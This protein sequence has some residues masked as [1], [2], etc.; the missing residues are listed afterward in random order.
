MALTKS[1]SMPP[2]EAFR[3]LSQD[4]CFGL[5]RDVLAAANGGDHIGEHAVP[6]GIVGSKKN[7]VVSDA[8]DHVGEGLLFWFRR[9]EPVA[10]F[11]VLARFFLAKRCFHLSPFLPFFIHPLDPVGNPANAA[12]KKGHAQVSKSF[13]NAAIHQAGELDKSLH[14][15]TDRMHEY[16]TV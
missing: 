2:V 3:V 15:P 14:R 16:E 12:F 5:F 13:R 9:K 1:V 6:M 10:M 8:L 11:D 7:L 4:F